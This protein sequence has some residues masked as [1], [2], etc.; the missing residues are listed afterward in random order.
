MTL[1]QRTMALF[2]TL[3]G[4]PPD[5]AIRAPGRVNLIGEH[6]DYNDG[7]VLPAAIGRQ[8]IVAARRRGDD[9]VRMIAADLGNA[10]SEFDLARPVDRAPDQPWSDY[11]RGMAATMQQQGVKLGGVDLLVAGDIPQGSGLSSSASLSV[12][13]GMALAGLFAPGQFDATRMALTAQAAECDFVGMRC[14]NMDQLASAHGVADHALL[15]DCRTLDVRPVAL[16]ADAAILIVHSGISRG[17]VDGAYNERRAQCEAV[18][19]QL[20]AAALRDVSLDRLDAARA[21]LDATAYR[22]ARHVVTENARTLAAADA[23]KGGDLVTLGALMAAS[24]ASMRDD[25]DISLP[26][27]DRL[28]AVMQRAIGARGGARMTGGGFGGAV[29]A[30]VEADAIGDVAAA[31][32]AS[33]RTPDGRKPA[34]M[35]E[36]ASAGASVL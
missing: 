5:L 27:I 12:A 13:T 8:S 32:E 22:R 31:V 35:I 25:F 9:V 7:F 36:R 17:L 15:I 20:G 18:A 2:G 16:P 4:A 34:I 11:L 23:M 14:G 30:L 3:V 1:A 24:H 29:V 10:T 28:A 33:Y 26:A 19:R 6:T 21:G